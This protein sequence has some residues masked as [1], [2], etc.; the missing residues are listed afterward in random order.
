MELLINFIESLLSK[1]QGNFEVS[2]R[3]SDFIFGSIQLLYYKCHKVNFR[4]GSS[5]INS[6]DWI[7]NKKATLNLK[8][9]DD[10][11]F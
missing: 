10:K 6:L 2:M 11:C 3:G 9:K 4:S 1:H 8:N 5:Y 7:R